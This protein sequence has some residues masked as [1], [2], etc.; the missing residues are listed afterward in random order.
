M[1]KLI[2]FISTVLQAQFISSLNPTIYPIVS[3][4]PS[5]KPPVT[6]YFLCTNL[7]LVPNLLFSSCPSPITI[8]LGVLASK[9]YMGMQPNGTLHLSGLP[10]T[11]TNCV[12]DI[13]P[14]PGI[15]EYTLG[16]YTVGQGILPTWTG[17]PAL[18]QV[19]V[20]GC[21]GTYQVSYSPGNIT[22]NCNGN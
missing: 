21:S 20:I 18:P 16:I 2:F 11:C 13:F 6:I 19:N 10:V 14:S 3:G 12:Q 4:D 8:N 5:V 1:R 22:V 17:Y 9:L 7:S 15:G